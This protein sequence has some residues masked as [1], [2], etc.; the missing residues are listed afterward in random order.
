VGAAGAGR[1]AGAS[2][3]LAHRG[4]PRYLV[5]A[6]RGGAE[7]GAEDP[8]TLEQDICAVDAQN[9][10]SDQEWYEPTLVRRYVPEIPPT[11]P[12]GR[13]NPHP[14][15]GV[16]GGTARFPDPAR[17]DQSGIPRGSA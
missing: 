16:R 3:W 12:P 7:I 1:F 8:Y 4:L 6:W 15:D 2:P 17:P 9:A 5:R 13:W 11:A 14:V 10:I